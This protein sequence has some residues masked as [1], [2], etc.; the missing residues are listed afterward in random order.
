MPY[1]PGPEAQSYIDLLLNE[2]D[3]GS[4]DRKPLPQHV[5]II[6]DGNGRWAQEQGLPR[7]EG[8]RRGIE[9]V[10][11]VAQACRK[12]EIPYLTLYA[13]STENWKRPKTEIAALMK[14]LRDFL[15]D[16]IPEMKENEIRLKGIGNLPQLPLYVQHQLQKTEKV[17]REGQMMQLGLALSY[18]SRDEITCA[19]QSLA[20]KVRDKKIRVQDIDQQMVSDHLFTA[21]MPDPDL[22]I[23]TSGE[24]RISNYLLWQ[25]AYAEIHI[26][27]VLWPNFRDVHFYQAIHDYLSRDR[28]FGGVRTAL[29]APG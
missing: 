7:I 25:I 20:A 15:R 19:V 6:M 18:G 16:E 14:L 23:R 4:S 8:H 13:F 2:G 24:F 12:L 17:T 27:P 10:R 11:S 5:A 21:G 3:N 29:P 26:S 1:N 9:S 22:M 28:R